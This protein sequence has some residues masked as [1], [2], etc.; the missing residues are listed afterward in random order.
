MNTS[1]SIAKIASAYVAF[2]GEVGKIA[3]DADNPFHKNKYATLDQIIDDVRPILNKHKLAV[4]QNVSGLEGNVTVKTLLLHESGEWFESDG[5]TLKPQKQDPQ[6]AGGAV[7][8]AR[9]YDLC[10]FLSLN[11]GEDDDGNKAS[12]YNNQNGQQNHSQSSNGPKK[13]SNKQLNLVDD[14]I[15]R[16][17]DTHEKEW[18]DVYE[19]LKT[20]LGTQNEMENF[21][22]QEASKGIK[23]LQS[24][25]DKQEQG[26]S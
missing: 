10:A 9:R 23:L 5:T 17:A 4:M 22:T 3:K 6:G 18:Q 14:L 16:N 25:L 24:W 7:T 21:T 13:A 20:K 8:Y 26:A 1:D 19:G 15:R 2:T 11:T 12:G